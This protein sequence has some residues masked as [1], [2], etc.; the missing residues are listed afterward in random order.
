M[1]EQIIDVS[2]IVYWKAT[3]AS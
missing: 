2:K 1:E 3:C